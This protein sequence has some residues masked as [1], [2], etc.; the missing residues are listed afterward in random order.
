MV[1]HLWHFTSNHARQSSKCY[2]QTKCL[3]NDLEKCEEAFNQVDEQTK[4][5]NDSVIEVTIFVYYFVTSFDVPS[6]SLPKT[7][8]LS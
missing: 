3:F 2:T 6:V 5:G 1:K 8:N 7:L 4:V